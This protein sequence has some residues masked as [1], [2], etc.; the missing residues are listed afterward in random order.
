MAAFPP[1]AC[2]EAAMKKRLYDRFAVEVPILTWKERQF[3]RVSI[4]GYNTASDV[5]AL[6]QA[7]RACLGW[8]R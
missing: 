8:I 6:A 4:Q 2:D 7:L 5:D 3:V 1:P